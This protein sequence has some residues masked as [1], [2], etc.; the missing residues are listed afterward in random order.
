MKNA[1]IIGW[2]KSGKGAAKLLLNHGIG[3]SVYADAELDL[4]SYPQVDNVSKLDYFDVI[5]GKDTLV[6]SPSVPM[7]HPL[8]EYARRFNLSVIGEIELGYKFCK[9]NIIAITGTNG[10]TTTT[11]LIGDIVN[12]GGIKAYTLGNIG[13]S[14]CESVDAI[15]EREIAVL[16]VSSF[17]LQSV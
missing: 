10:K 17:Q 6:L 9:G 8:V 14:F 15:G 7:D 3:V 12:V 2:G 1:V 16:E 4:S 11:K 5:S 13:E